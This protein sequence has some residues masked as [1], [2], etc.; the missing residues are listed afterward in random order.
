[1]AEL[2]EELAEYAHDAWSGWMRYMFD[3]CLDAGQEGMVIPKE[4]VAR[5]KRQMQTDYNDLPESEKMS[6][7]AEADKMMTIV[8]MDEQARVLA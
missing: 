2:R 6:D 3:Q 8:N 5:W 1:M 4:F 7:R